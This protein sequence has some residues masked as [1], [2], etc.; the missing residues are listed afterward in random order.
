MGVMPG[1]AEEALKTLDAAK[2]LFLIGGF[3]GCVAD[4]CG[5]LGLWPDRAIAQEWSGIAHFNA[6]AELN[7]GLTH[8]ENSRLA[9]TAYV[10]EA[11]TLM[12]RGITRLFHPRMGNT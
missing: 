12:L 9:T 10:D 4:I 7:N 11:V 8:E 2:P 3:G 6:T 5:R 1:V